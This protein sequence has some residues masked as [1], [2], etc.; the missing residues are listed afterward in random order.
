MNVRLEHANMHVVDVNAMVNFLQTA[1]P[2]FQVELVL[3]I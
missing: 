1:F 3:I 2:S